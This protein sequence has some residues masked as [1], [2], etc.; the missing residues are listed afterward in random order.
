METQKIAK[1][2]VK[3]EHGIGGIMVP[4]FRLYYKLQ[5]SRQY[6]AGTNTGI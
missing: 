6:G 3:R 1:A 5:S 4:D 2:I